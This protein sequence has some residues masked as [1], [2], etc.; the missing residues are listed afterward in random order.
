MFS[1]T[2]QPLVSSHTSPLNLW[3]L[4]DGCLGG[5]PDVFMDDSQTIH[6]AQ[7][8]YGLQLNINKCEAFIIGGNDGDRKKVWLT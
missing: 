6:G 8:D 1:I 5:D 2:I 3:Y 7:D 4:D